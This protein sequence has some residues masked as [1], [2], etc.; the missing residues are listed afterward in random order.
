[1]L[2][3]GDGGTSGLPDSLDPTEFYKQL[4]RNY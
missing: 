1:M 2:E 3:V 4:A